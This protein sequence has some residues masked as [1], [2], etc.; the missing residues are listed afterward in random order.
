MLCAHPQCDEHAYSPAQASASLRHPGAN[1]GWCRALDLLAGKCCFSRQI[2][3]QFNKLFGWLF[4]QSA[5]TKKASYFWVVSCGDYFF[6]SEISSRSSAWRDMSSANVQSHRPVLPSLQQ[7]QIYT[8]G[9]SHPI[10]SVIHCLQFLLIMA[11][12]PT[13][14]LSSSHT[15][16]FFLSHRFFLAASSQKAAIFPHQGNP[17]PASCVR[18]HKWKLQGDPGKQLRT[19]RIIKLYS[20][21][22]SFFKFSSKTA[23]IT[24]WQLA[25]CLYCFLFSTGLA[26]TRSIKGAGRACPHSWVTL[27]VHR[28][29]PP[30]WRERPPAKTPPS[31]LEHPAQSR[32]GS[33]QSHSSPQAAGEGAGM[34]G[35]PEEG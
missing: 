12:I 24:A 3:P 27:G 1:L 22:S 20:L 28:H 35:G 15:S 7:E 6:S 11:I 32:P 13:K 25:W 30:L 33:T 29:P 9:S 23:T 34:R 19:Q 26:P 16:Y 31:T 4:S 5:A 2:Q 10:H 8:R 14:N 18:A 17:P 21:N